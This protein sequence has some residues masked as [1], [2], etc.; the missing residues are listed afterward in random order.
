MGHGFGAC[1]LV[2]IEEAGAHVLCPGCVAGIDVRKETTG[3]TVAITT[4][5]T[6]SITIV[7][8][9][10]IAD[11]T[12]S[13]RD[14]TPTISQRG[15]ERTSSRVVPVFQLR[16]LFQCV[17]DHVFDRFHVVIRRA[18]DFFHLHRLKY[19][20]CFELIKCS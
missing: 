1:I 16:V 20:D 10:V 5:L 12:E 15:S 9:A 6:K 7:W 2:H 14:I 8:A 3:A 18:F 17:L 13:V 19:F 4:A 11:S